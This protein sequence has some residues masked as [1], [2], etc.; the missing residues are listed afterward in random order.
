M[1]LR[2]RS[3]GSQCPDHKRAALGSDARRRR[4]VS[5]VAGVTGS[6]KEGEDVHRVRR[7][8]GELKDALAGEGAHYASV[9]RSPEFVSASGFSVYR[10]R[11]RH[12]PRETKI[13]VALDAY[14]VGDRV[15]FNETEW[16]G[17]NLPGGLA[18][19]V[20]DDGGV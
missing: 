3:D 12:K 2:S 9:N 18:G 13:A 17:Q 14:G 19:K 20:T 1:T 8:L 7:R 10:R 6:E 5:G 16:G 4:L 15:C 11:R